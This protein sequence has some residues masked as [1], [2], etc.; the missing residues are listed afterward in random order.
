MNIESEEI[1]ESKSFSLS[2]SMNDA[3][4]AIGVSAAT[5]CLSPAVAFYM[6]L[7]A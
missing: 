4:W 2:F 3:L 7:V 1:A 5:L 6:L